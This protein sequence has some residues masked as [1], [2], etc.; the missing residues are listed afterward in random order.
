[1]TMTGTTLDLYVGYSFLYDN[2]KNLLCIL[3]QY[4]I[5]PNV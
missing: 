2:I 3:S 1:M 4:F 5:D